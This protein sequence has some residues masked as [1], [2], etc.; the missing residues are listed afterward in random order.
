MH[1]QLYILFHVH[2][3]FPSSVSKWTTVLVLA[4]CTTTSSNISA[5]P[6]P[7]SIFKRLRLPW[8]PPWSASSFDSV[9]FATM[10]PWYFSGCVI[11][12][13]DFNFL[14]Y[15]LNRQRALEVIVPKFLASVAASSTCVSGRGRS[16]NNAFRS[17]RITQCESFFRNVAYVM[18]FLGV[19]SY[20][21][22][23]F[24]YIGRDARV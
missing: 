24:F 5:L 22:Q 11:F 14:V 13:C 3:A 23:K 4:L 8:L 21:F 20:R 19:S 15:S 7:V 6:H 17:A 9:P 2:A 12:S 1:I 16:E 18:C 10:Q